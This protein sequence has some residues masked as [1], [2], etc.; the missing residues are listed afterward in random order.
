MGQTQGK[1]TGSAHTG[2][3]SKKEHR[4]PTHM[5]ESVMQAIQRVRKTKSDREEPLTNFTK[6]LLKAPK[7]NNIFYSI[8]AVFNTFDK[9]NS[10]AIDVAE[11]QEALSRLTMQDVTEEETKEFFDE[12][13]IYE[14][15]HISFKEFIVC[16]AIGYVLNTIPALRGD[17]VSAAEE[18]TPHAGGKTASPPVKAV[19]KRIRGLKLDAKTGR[20]PSFLMG[21]GPKIADAF[22]LVMDAYLTFDAEGKGY[23]TKSDMNDFIQRLGAKSPSKSTSKSARTMDFGATAFLSEERMNEMDWDK[24][25]QISYSEFVY[26][27]LGWVGFEDDDEDDVDEGKSGGGSGGSSRK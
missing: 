25:G 19:N 14:D 17:E 20:R 22:N 16:L 18:A 5:E 8:K 2:K 6:I 23:I 26:S 3:H 12:A 27:F 9:D 7:M 1:T 11:L 4:P 24:S 21:E 13:D 15:G 10:G